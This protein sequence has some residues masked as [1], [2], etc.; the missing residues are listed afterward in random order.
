MI[1]TIG[2]NEWGK[3][4]ITISLGRLFYR[5]DDDDEYDETFEATCRTLVM[6]IFVVKII[7]IIIIVVV[8]VVIVSGVRAFSRTPPETTIKR[9]H[10]HVN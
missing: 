3:D 4:Y 5:D 7:I 1:Y 10:Y 6:R 9:F 2:L 8:I